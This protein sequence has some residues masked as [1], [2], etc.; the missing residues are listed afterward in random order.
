MEVLY[1]DCSTTTLSSYRLGG[2]FNF[3]DIFFTFSY[4]FKEFLKVGHK[5][6]GPQKDEPTLLVR[7]SP[8]ALSS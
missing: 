2:N 1:S 3:V 7:L 6:I 5:I 4:Y 8:Q